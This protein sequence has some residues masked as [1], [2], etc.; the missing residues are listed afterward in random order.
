M[1]DRML[2]E[3]RREPDP[4]FARSLRERL[5]RSE[6][7]H[8]LTRGRTVRVLAGACAAILLVALFTVPSVRVSA[9]AFLDLFRVRRFA[10]VQFKESRFEAL[11][12][13]GEDGESLVFDRVEKLHDPGRPA[14]V[15][16]REAASR[17]VGYAVGAPRYLP[18]GLT[19]DSVFVQEEGAVRLMVSEAKLRALLQRLDLNDVQVPTGLDGRWIEVRKPPIVFQAFRSP[20]GTRT[21]FL[22]AKSPE[23]SVPSGWDVERLAEIGLRVLGLDAGEAR[24]MARSTDWRSTLLVPVPMNASTFRQVTVHG[25][26]GLMIMTTERNAEGLRRESALLLWSEGGRVFCLESPL[27]GPALMQMAESVS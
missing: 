20:R 7:S 19:P 26:P 24:R 10:A 17:Q 11:R 12:S 9:Q 25:Q 6:R 14:Y 13:S 4:E 23:I 2:E 27:S 22:Q 15:A 18:G 21:M 5:R 1:D 3:Y 8:A 16:S